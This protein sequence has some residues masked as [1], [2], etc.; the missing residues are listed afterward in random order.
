MVAKKDEKAGTKSGKRIIYYIDN[1]EKSA[2]SVCMNLN[3]SLKPWEVSW[4]VKFFDPKVKEA[5]PDEII[6]LA[7][8]NS[9]PPLQFIGEDTPQK[10]A[11]KFFSKF[12]GDKTALKKLKLISCEAGLVPPESDESLAKKFF[13][14]MRTKFS[15]LTGYAATYPPHSLG[16][17]V[18]VLTCVGLGF[19]G[20]KIGDVSG[21]VH[22]NAASQKYD[23]YKELQGIRLKL[24]TQEQQSELTQLIEELKGFTN[25]SPGYSRLPIITSFDELE[26]PYNT[27]AA[28]VKRPDLSVEVLVA[29]NHFKHHLNIQRL[30]VADLSM[31]RVLEKIIKELESNSDANQEKI[32]SIVDECSNPPNTLFSNLKTELSQKIAAADKDIEFKLD[33][34]RV[35]T[36]KSSSTQRHSPEEFLIALSS[37]QQWFHY[38]LDR[39][40]GFGFGAL[41]S[42]KGKLA[43]FNDILAEKLSTSENASA[44]SS[45]PSLKIQIENLESQIKQEIEGMQSIIK[46][47]EPG[48]KTN[49]KSWR[50]KEKWNNLHGWLTDLEGQLKIVN[51]DYLRVFDEQSFK[52]ILESSND[53]TL[54]ISDFSGK[55]R[56]Q[57]DEKLCAQTEL[58]E[59]LRTLN[60]KI[61]ILKS[62]FAELKIKK[63]EEY[64]ATST[65]KPKDLIELKM[66]EYIKKHPNSPKAAVMKSLL[67]FYQSGNPEKWR[68]VEKA[69]RENPTWNS[70]V[71]YSRVAA[72][73]RTMESYKTKLEGGTTPEITPPSSPG[74]FKS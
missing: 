73:K 10:L 62:K 71:I 15:H 36:L 21:Y 70:G 30:N 60:V 68:E 23:R 65:S 5:T 69:M 1:D 33:S 17:Y 37:N 67:D 2:N 7:H 42:G 44:A 52:P 24:R 11:I 22:L 18:Q 16:G 55:T 3:Q 9:D 32:M 26:R 8:T 20:E 28:G 43:K 39:F 41:G 13:D 66:D 6:L 48:V 45:S 29:L 63:K 72:M 4:E 40:F 56:V 58:Q 53:K 64:N 54:A 35:F 38:I 47:I 34:K 49:S 61:D 14:E 51:L 59:K 27:Y 31:I 74:S 57:I 25:R 19:N 12:T 50:H 46:S